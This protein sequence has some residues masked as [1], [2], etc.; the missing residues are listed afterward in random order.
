MLINKIKIDKNNILSIDSGTNSGED[1]NPKFSFAN[2]FRLIKS[3]SLSILFALIFLAFLSQIGSGQ[4]ALIITPNIT[5]IRKQGD[6]FYLECTVTGGDGVGFYWTY[7]NGTIIPYQGTRFISQSDQ[8]LGHNCSIL[9]FNDIRK[10]DEGIYTCVAN[11][12]QYVE[13]KGI[14]LRIYEPIKFT[15]APKIQN[16]TLGQNA[17]IHCVATSMTNL[18]VDWKKNAKI[19]TK[20]G[21]YQPTKDGL[22]VNNFDKQD[23][24]TFTCRAKEYGLF[25]ATAS[26]DI[27]VNVWYPTAIID[28][29]DPNIRALIG[30]QVNLTCRTE[31]NPIST[32][33]WYNN[34]FLVRNVTNDIT[35][36]N[37]RNGTS[38]LL[39]NLRK[40]NDFGRYIC[41]AYNSIK[42]PVEFVYDVKEADIPNEVQEIEIIAV[43]ANSVEIRIMPPAYDG[44]SEVLYY[45]LQYKSQ[46]LGWDNSSILKIPADSLRYTIT[47]LK[48]TTKYDM[49]IVPVNAKGKGMPFVA[50]FSTNDDTSPSSAINLMTRFSSIQ[51]LFYILLPLLFKIIFH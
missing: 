7:P 50:N 18:S 6:N 44:G 33:S 49:E 46:E 29:P 39:I 45:M 11:V 3:T 38:V 26:I 5:Q 20:S 23:N 15:H 2:N 21:K 37:D 31:G 43:K 27:D 19:I 24:G 8:C 28:K 1:A 47:G 4:A 16:Y 25:Y 13:K 42:G 30:E 9:L 14:L 22:W 12:K 35:V 51:L 48:P 36:L 41:R 34:N 17:L 10:E 32:I 40:V